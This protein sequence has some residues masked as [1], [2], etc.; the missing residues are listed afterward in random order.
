M[1]SSKVINETNTSAS[2]SPPCINKTKQTTI[3]R[4]QIEWTQTCNV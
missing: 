4:V 3:F 1:Y 2:H